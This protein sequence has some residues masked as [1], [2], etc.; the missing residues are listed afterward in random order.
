MYRNKFVLKFEKVMILKDYRY[1]S[2]R[3]IWWDSIYT[4]VLT[5]TKF[6]SS[7]VLSLFLILKPSIYPNE[8]TR[9]NFNLKEEKKLSSC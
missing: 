5:A 7:Y 3:I 2:I 4:Y 1:L 8:I 9:P 6:S